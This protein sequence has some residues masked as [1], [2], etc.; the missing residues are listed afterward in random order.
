MSP[1]RDFEAK[2]FNKINPAI[3]FSVTRY[4]LAVGVFIA[5]VVFGLV[6]AGGLGVDQLPTINIPVVIVS[7]LD[8]GAT[9]SV[10]DQ[11][12][13]QV[14]ENTVTTISGITD[15]S[16]SSQTGSSI[17][18]VFFDQSTDKN[19]DANQVASQVSAAI[20]L[21][22][23]GVNAPTIKTFDPTSVAVV[24]LGLS[25]K[26]VGLDEVSDYVTND[27]LPNLER[28][29][30]VANITDDGAPTR[31][32][33]VLLNPDKLRSY[34]LTPQPSRPRSRTRRSIPRSAPSI[35]SATCSPSRRWTSPPTR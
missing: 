2:I 31:E 22:P 28:V 16:S 13:T 26:G 32:F 17:V 23:P 15:I 24:Q 34:N 1:L 9:P 29:N 14:I 8:P 11:S 10:I 4:V 7:T 21:L 3:R 27:L 19:S 6:S 20:R 18:A 35:T 12:I 33:Q 25:A 30:G 5:I